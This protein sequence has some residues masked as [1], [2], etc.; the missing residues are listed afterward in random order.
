MK[1]LVKVAVNLATMAEF[2]KKLQ[3]GELDR[4]CIRGETYCL[5]EDP[6]VGYSI[7]EAANCEEFEA[8]FSP[9]RTYYTEAEYHEV[10]PPNES[11]ALLFDKMKKKQQH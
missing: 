1:F 3:G 9:W 8:K 6:A 4:S 5:K 7:W 2:G 10:I 11:M